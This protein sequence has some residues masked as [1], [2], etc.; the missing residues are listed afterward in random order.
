LSLVT[1]QG[2]TGQGHNAT[3]YGEPAAERIP[4]SASIFDSVQNEKPIPAYPASG[5]I[6]REGH[7]G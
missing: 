2:V 7:A 6:A 4:A 1:L 3:G 5:K